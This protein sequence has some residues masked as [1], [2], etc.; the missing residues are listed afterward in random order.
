MILTSMAE[1]LFVGLMIV[2]L[3]HPRVR[4]RFA[5]SGA[6]RAAV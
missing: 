3:I 6:M 2:W 1:A 4:A 5:E